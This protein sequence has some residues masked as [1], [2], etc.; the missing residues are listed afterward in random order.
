MDWIKQ[1][2]AMF[3]TWT[4]T[5]QKMWD[6]FS[7]NVS[8]FGKSPGEKMWAQTVK[9]GEDLVKNSLAA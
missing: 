8:G 4:D 3:K 1:S 5:Q 9:A 2:E 7:E 6:T